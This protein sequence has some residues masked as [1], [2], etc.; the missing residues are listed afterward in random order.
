MADSGSNGSFGN[1]AYTPPV[2]GDPRDISMQTSGEP[3]GLTIMSLPPTR[4][5]AYTTQVELSGD[6]KE[7]DKYVP[8]VT[9]Q[10][11]EMHNQNV[12]GYEIYNR[13]IDLGDG[14]YMDC[15]RNFTADKARIHVPMSGGG[16]LGPMMF[17]FDGQSENCFKNNSFIDKIN[18]LP[19]SF[20]EYGS[21]GFSIPRFGMFSGYNGIGLSTNSIGEIRANAAL[22]FN[23]KASSPYSTAV[24]VPSVMCSDATAGISSSI[25]FQ[26]YRFLISIDARSYGTSVFSDACFGNPIDVGS[27]KF[28]YAQTCTPTGAFSDEYKVPMVVYHAYLNGDKVAESDETPLNLW[29]TSTPAYSLGHDGVDYMMKTITCDG[30]DSSVAIHQAMYSNNTSTHDDI[31]RT[32]DKL[33]AKWGF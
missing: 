10:M 25:D 27:N 14:K 11:A 4:P 28:A 16:S 24:V 19:A 6:V 12:N 13:P 20:S 18:G 7:A 29:R 33:A 23:P 15:S 5:D 17:S 22:K 9:Q 26:G 3:A 1:G 32:T 21:Y 30:V 31:L 8:L 2:Y